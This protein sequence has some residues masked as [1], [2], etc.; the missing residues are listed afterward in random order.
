MKVNC[1]LKDP[2]EVSKWGLQGNPPVY[3]QQDISVW[4]VYFIGTLNSR[5]SN[6]CRRKANEIMRLKLKLSRISLVAIA[7]RSG[8]AFAF[9][10]VSRGPMRRDSP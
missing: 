3:V 8:L 10:F 1:C 5:R 7:L 4:T 6:C 2:S 9:G